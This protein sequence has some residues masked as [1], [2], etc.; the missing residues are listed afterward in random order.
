MSTWLG[1]FVRRYRGGWWRLQG[2][3]MLLTTFWP[4]DYRW[5]TTYRIGEQDYQIRRYVRGDDPRYFEV[6]GRVVSQVALVRGAPRMKAGEQRA[7]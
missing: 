3:R 1:A 2:E 4:Q 6:W 5:G 7:A